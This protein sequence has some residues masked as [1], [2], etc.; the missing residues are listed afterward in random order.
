MLLFEGLAPLLLW[1]SR[2]KIEWFRTPVHIS[3]VRMLID[4]ISLLFEGLVRG[5]FTISVIA[6][7]R[8]TSKVALIFHSSYMDIY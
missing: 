7:L 8:I 1:F 2:N 4:L 5:L 6:L 3:E